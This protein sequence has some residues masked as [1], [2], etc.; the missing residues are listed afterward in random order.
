M[1]AVVSLDGRLVSPEAA[2]VSVFDRGFLYGDSVCEAC[3]TYGGLP[4][5]L[6]EH[7]AELERSAVLVAFP[8]VD[9]ALLRSEILAAL[10]ARGD[11]ESYVR[12]VLTRGTGITLGLDPALARTPLRVVVAVDVPVT[13]AWIYE[14]GIAV[15]TVGTARFSEGAR[16]VG[17]RLGVDLLQRLATREARAHG[18]DDALLL[19]AAGEVL[20]GAGS[21]V[22][23][24]KAGAL[25]TPPDD[26]GIA[27]GVAREKVLELARRGGLRVE[28][29]PFRSEE[30]AIADEVFL[31]SSLRE[32]VPVIA[33]DGKSA[34]GGRPGPITAR[35]LAAY[36]ALALARA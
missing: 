6:D 13:P 31:A 4:F 17:S 35:L 22:F 5:A 23:L 29:R 32:L 33:C 9:F 18:A 26:A 21:S 7:L 11:L 16:A 2:E 20:E 1:N 25:V 34:G 28:F 27:G 14:R 12:V 8:F 15:V 36:R 24:V 19:N 3:R 10:R 30:L